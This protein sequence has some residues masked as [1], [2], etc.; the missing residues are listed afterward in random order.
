MSGTLSQSGVA[1]EKLTSIC[2]K[3]KKLRCCAGERGAEADKASI[4]AGATQKRA[5]I[6]LRLPSHAVA[7]RGLP[8]QSYLTHEKYSEAS[9]YRDDGS[10]LVRLFACDSDYHQAQR[11]CLVKTVLLLGNLACLSWWEDDH[12][13]IEAQYE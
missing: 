2:I 5:Y 9:S 13:S 12:S 7:A 11:S 4:R 1:G 6:Q 8:I 10:I 3:A